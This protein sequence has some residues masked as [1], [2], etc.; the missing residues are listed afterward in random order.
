MA[1]QKL[2]VLHILTLTWIFICILG[3]SVNA[4]STT[5]TILTATS[6]AKLNLKAP[7]TQPVGPV[8][9]S[10]NNVYYDIVTFQFN[11]T[12]GEE[13][14]ATA[15]TD[16][17]D[18]EKATS[19]G[20]AKAVSSLLSSEDLTK[21]EKDGATIKIY[22]LKQISDVLITDTIAKRNYNDLETAV[23]EWL[24]ENDL[25]AALTAQ[26]EKAAEKKTEDAENAYAQQ[27]SAI[28]GGELATNTLTI[29]STDTEYGTVGINYTATS[30]LTTSDATALSEDEIVSP[31]SIT[32]K[33]NGKTYNAKLS[34][35]DY[36]S[37][38]VWKH[39]VA[40]TVP[41]GI[42]ENVLEATL[43][44][45]G[46][47]STIV[48]ELLEKA[49]HS[50]SHNG[51][52]YVTI[53]LDTNGNAIYVSNGKTE[54]KIDGKKP[55]AIPDGLKPWKYSAGYA[56][57]AYDGTLRL[58]QWNL[59]EDVVGHTV[60]MANAYSFLTDAEVDSI[61]YAIKW[62]VDLPTGYVILPLWTNWDDNDNLKLTYPGASN[63]AWF[64]AFVDDHYYD[65][66]DWRYWKLEIV[67]SGNSI[68]I[69]D[70]V[71]RTWYGS[72]ILI[73]KPTAASAAGTAPNSATVV[74][75][76]SPATGQQIATAAILAVIC[77]TGVATFAVKSR[78]L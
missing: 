78:K 64:G 1:K 26:N 54:P 66:A 47:N 8:Q 15:W 77:V 76:T 12:A 49:C 36:S 17:D 2:P 60:D 29:T 22:V 5:T 10:D 14:G 21:I 38:T 42:P 58:W 28:S 70:I 31:V 30:T 4:A 57:S 11:W 56:K 53:T 46:L 63:Y 52:Y 55:I 51:T 25:T 72:I 19:L 73:G 24:D 48:G 69:E 32:I 71:D 65:P 68:Y 45:T 40:L 16:L 23:Q 74:A 34:I 50:P 9:I 3:A 35:T 13:S 6:G 7:T 61:E 59:N 75:G 37:T 67:V 41:D 44:A 27:L 39:V 18:E 20:T 43:L 33:G 62:N